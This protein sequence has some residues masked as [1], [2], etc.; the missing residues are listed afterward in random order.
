MSISDY[1]R[2]I[3]VASGG[4]LAEAPR[5]VLSVLRAR[6]GHQIGP[7]YHSLFHL[8]R[9]PAERWSEFILSVEANRITAELNGRENYSFAR[10]KLTFTEH[11]LR[12]GIPTIPIIAA[13]LPEQAASGGKIPV[14]STPQALSLVMADAP[15]RVFVKAV[16]G[17]H[18][19]GA[20]IAVRERGQWVFNDRRGSVDDLHRY[21]MSSGAGGWLVQPVIES[22]PSLSRIMGKR[23]LGTVRATTYL[24]EEGPRLLLPVMK[25]PASDNLVDNFSLGMQGNLVAPIDIETGV[26]GTAWISKSRSW[27]DIVPMEVHPDTHHQISGIALPY[28]P[29]TVT[30]ALKAQECTSILPTQA[31]DIAITEVGPIV[32]ETNTLYGVEMMEVAYARGI[33]NDLAPICA[34]HQ[35]LLGSAR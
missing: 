29:E 20:F 9:V 18:G 21:C 26:L 5:A 23:A 24:A 28:W 16:D 8:E 25:I 34:M 35:R 30:L 12:H 3:G 33:R 7:K 2:A 11:C 4:R 13:L 15:D 27:P 19:D 31:W 14:V 6:L 1:A 22:H 17:A 32:V 10:N